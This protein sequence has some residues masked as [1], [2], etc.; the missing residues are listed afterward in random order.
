MN[1]PGNSIMQKKTFI[2]G[3]QKTGCLL[4]SG[5]LISLMSKEHQPF[6]V[7][8]EKNSVLDSREKFS[9][10]NCVFK[11]LTLRFRSEIGKSRISLL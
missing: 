3:H 10:V 1:K 8:K 7:Q 9:S 5:I 4:L 2:G 11:E 6:S